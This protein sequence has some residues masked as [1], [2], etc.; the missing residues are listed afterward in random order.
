MLGL[1]EEKILTALRQICV[2]SGYAVISLAEIKESADLPT[3][4]YCEV[5]DSL[6]LLSSAGYINLRFYEGEEFCLSV[7]PKG[8]EGRCS[9]S[10]KQGFFV[11]FKGVFVAFGV[12]FVGAFLGALIGG[13]L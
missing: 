6:L 12:S 5:E 7:L 2:G 8:R 11:R 13:A 1:N 10:A 3:I 9:E 4:N